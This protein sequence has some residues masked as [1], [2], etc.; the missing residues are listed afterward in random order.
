[1]PIISAI[2]NFLLDN[3]E[4]NNKNNIK[5]LEFLSSL[6]VCFS[7]IEGGCSYFIF[8]CVVKPDDINK[9]NIKKSNASLKLIYN[10]GLKT[11]NKKKIWNFIIDVSNICYIYFFQSHF[12]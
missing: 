8:L 1:M 6:F 12:L 4:E 10:D 2:A 5:N 3:I 7:L 9:T 11:N